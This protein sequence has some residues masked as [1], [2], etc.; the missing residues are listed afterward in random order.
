MFFVWSRQPW[1]VN[2]ETL[3]LEWVD[4]SKPPSAYT[5]DYMYVSVKLFGIPLL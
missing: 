3:L 1:S 2:R 4:S 5:F